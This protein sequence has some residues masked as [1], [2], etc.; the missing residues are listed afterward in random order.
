MQKANKFGQNKSANG[1][2]FCGNFVEGAFGAGDHFVGTEALQDF[3]EFIKV[4]T[5]DDGD[6]FVV[7]ASALGDEESGFNIVGSDDDVSGLGYACVHESTFLFGVV[8][9]DRFTGADQI[10]DRG[11]IAVNQNIRTRAAA[12]VGDDARAEMAVADNDD[13]IFHFTRKH[14][15]SFLRI[16]ALKRLEKKNRDD[17][18]EKNALSPEGIEDR[19]LAGENAEIESVEER[20]AQGKMG[21]TVEGKSA[22]GKPDEK[23]R[24]APATL[25]KK[26]G[27][28]NPKE[29][30]HKTVAR[31]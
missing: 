9:D 16:V 8:H 19:E 4:A 7:V 28:A 3:S 6:F 17:D 5:D 23:K 13:V 18:S 26:D 31:C 14:A 10:V 29:A 11:G 2:N 21:E 20:F 25:A 15:A 1:S 27:K 22:Q 24:E 30:A 12:K